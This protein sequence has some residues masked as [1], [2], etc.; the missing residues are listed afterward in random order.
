MVFN[1]TTYDP[2]PPT[3]V[4]SPYEG[5]SVLSPSARLVA[6]RLAG[7]DGKALGYVLRRVRATRFG[8]SYQVDIGQ[9]LATICMPG[10]KVNI[11]FDERFFVTHHYHDGKSDILLYDLVHRRGA[12]D[13][14]RP[15]RHR[16][17]LP[18]LPLGRLDLLPDRRRR[19]GDHGG[20]RRGHP[21]RGPAVMR[22]LSLTVLVA[23]GL[24]AGCAGG[25]RRRRRRRVERSA[26]LPGGA[27]RQ[28]RRVRPQPGRRGRAVRAGRRAERARGAGGAGDRRAPAP[29]SRLGHGVQGARAGAAARPGR[30]D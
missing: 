3:V 1:G 17:A 19:P 6:S 18:A 4:D 26:R 13:H 23:A 20:E 14:R 29:R 30:G 11:S 21:H 10:A 16:G 9:K 27:G 28:D 5:D 2:M 12:S 15:G 25:Y 24:V 22:A 7:A 8:D